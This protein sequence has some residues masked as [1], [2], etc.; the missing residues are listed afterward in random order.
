[1]PKKSKRVRTFSTNES[2]ELKKDKTR[3]IKE[4][5]ALQKKLDDAREEKTVLL[6][7]KTHLE[8][9]INR[10]DS[11]LIRLKEDIRSL[12]KAKKY[13]ENGALVL[14]ALCGFSQFF[15]W[16]LILSVIFYCLIISIF[17]FVLWLKRFD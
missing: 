11:D 12:Q 15:H 16:Y 2:A 13:R 8:D 7:A 10:L 14:T 6:V 5:A 17:C 4:N 3:Y 9:K 1:M